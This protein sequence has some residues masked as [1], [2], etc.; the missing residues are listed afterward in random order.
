MNWERA[1]TD[2]QKEIRIQ[3]ILNT[4]LHLYRTIEFDKITFALIAKENQSARSN[5][6]KYFETKEEI[7]LEYLSREIALWSSAVCEDYHKGKIKEITNSTDFARYWFEKFMRYRDMVEILN[8]LYTTL[9][10]NVSLDSLRKIK[11]SMSAVISQL[12][13]VL[14]NTGIF[15][16]HQAVRDFL[17]ATLSFNMGFF[18]LLSM[19]EKQKEAMILE[20]LPVDETRVQ[21]LYIRSISS[22]IDSYKTK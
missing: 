22:F 17:E 16:D 5:I 13:V 8:L 15:P 21:S 18:P 20:G 3:G 12:N 7:F 2:E 9:E 19:T 10:K 11:R 4:T 6:Y 14:M 1:R